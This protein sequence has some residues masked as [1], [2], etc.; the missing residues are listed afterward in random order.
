MNDK[1]KIIGAMVLSFG[2]I[3][4]AISITYLAYQL[5]LWRKDIPEIIAPVLDEVEKV[6]E[7]VPSVLE[8]VRNSNTTIEKVVSEVRET[9]EAIPGIMDRADQIVAAVGHEA[10]KGAV[11]GIIGGIIMTPFDMVGGLGKGIA[12]FI[13]PQDME[14]LTEKDMKLLEQNA[15][16]LANKGE[17]GQVVTWENTESSNSGKITLMEKYHKNDR[18][19]RQVKIDIFLK[20]KDSRTVLLVGCQQPDGSW[21]TIEGGALPGK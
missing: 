9:R 11:K 12:H 19:C 1:S 18:E 15:L 5:N 16:E 8:E 7:M 17:V 10:G 13:N 4:V 2:L 14:Q 3:C 20:G 6:R 21:E